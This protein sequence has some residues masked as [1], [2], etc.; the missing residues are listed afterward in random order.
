LYSLA[1]DKCRVESASF[2]NGYVNVAIDYS[3][4]L[5]KLA[6]EYSSKDVFTRLIRVGSGVKVLVEHTSANPVHPLHIGSGRN[7]TLGDTYARLL[8]KLGFNAE[9]RFYVNDLG[10]QVATLVYGV[11]IVESKGLSRPEG[12]KPDHWYGV[13]YALTNILAELDRLRAELKQRVNR[14][15]SKAEEICRDLSKDV[16]PTSPLRDIQFTLCELAWKKHLKLDPLKYAKRLSALLREV[17]SKKALREQHAGLVEVANEVEEIKKVLREYRDFL[18]A[19]RAL[20]THYPDLYNAL[21]SA[22]TDYRKVEEDIRKI[23]LSAERGEPETIAVFRRV[24]ESVIEGFKQTLS[25]LGIEFNGFDFESSREILGTTYEVVSA[26]AKTKYART[27]EG[28]ALE[29]DLN[30]AAQEN[31]YIKGLFYPDQAG[32]F[33]IQRSDGTTLYVT[34]DIAYTLYK[35][36]KLGVQRVYNVI[37]VEQTREQKQLKAVLHLLGFT[38]EARN[39]NHFSYEMVHLKGMRM[40]GRRGRYYSLDEMLLDSEVKNLQKL[41]EREGNKGIEQLRYIARS[42]AVS[43]VRALLLSVDPNKVLVFDPKKIEESE[44]GAMIEYAFVRAQGVLRNLWRVE[45]L[46]SPEQVFSKLGE[47]AKSGTKL[48]LSP[49]EK[50]I[51]ELLLKFE[52]TLLEAYRE[53]KPN[54]VLEYAVELSTEFNRFYEKYPIISESDISAKS[55]RILITTL[56]LIILSELMDIIGLPKLKR[57]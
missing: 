33:V 45:F 32:R 56:A 14:L 23:M 46:E 29:V 6:E 10:R 9:T 53:M 52:N 24:A 12:L 3:G 25:D 37:A 36:K 40:S 15:L 47:L 57:M 48:N 44:Y 41:S 31:E 4:V 5:K 43:N 11:R 2:I 22:V 21:R 19:E 26:L 27:V 16:I 28:G 20:S 35:F 51:V 18:S 30:G 55:A 34:R 54:R 7:S 42:I 38:E 8:R 1:R 39:L 50:R 49:E 17:P 13:I